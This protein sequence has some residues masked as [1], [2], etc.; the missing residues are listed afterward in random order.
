MQFSWA[1]ESPNQRAG[2]LGIG[3][4]FPDVSRTRM[5][6]RKAAPGWLR[7]RG[8]LTTQLLRKGFH[9]SY[10][11]QAYYTLGRVSVKRRCLEIP[12]C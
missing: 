12:S 6:L 7:C 9:H 8:R 3:Q 10:Y 2:T 1:C 4:V 11:C 5:M